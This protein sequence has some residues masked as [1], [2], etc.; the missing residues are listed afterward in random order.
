[1]KL[2]GIAAA[3]PAV[4]VFSFVACSSGSGQLS[5]APPADAAD[6][7]DSADSSKATA[8][9][10]ASTP[11]CESPLEITTRA[12]FL[13]AVQAISPTTETTMDTTFGANLR[14]SRDLR[15]VGALDLDTTMLRGA[16]DSC[17]EDAGGCTPESFAAERTSHSPQAYGYQAATEYPTGVACATP[18][19]SGNCDRIVIAAGTVVRLQRVIE[20]SLF[21]GSRRHLVRFLRPCAQACNSDEVYCAASATC[22]KAGYDACIFCEGKSP[23]SCGCREGCGSKP[24]GA[25]CSG[26]TSDDTA[27]SGTC[28][29]GICA[30][31]FNRSDGR[32]A[33]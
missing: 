12:E 24:E 29:N 7:A 1:M 22:F 3:L 10:P 25:E 8:C 9:P 30:T 4:A 14:P 6:S 16:V 17:P 32:P 21:T 13:S 23:L 28:R 11:T 33:P 20:T 2:L 26:V 15:I 5:E 18:S 19:A 31:P 27:A